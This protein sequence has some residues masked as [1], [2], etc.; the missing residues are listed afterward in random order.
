MGCWN[1][2]CGLSRLPIHASRA[3]YMVPIVQAPYQGRCYSTDMW[4]PTDIAVVGEYN[5]Y[6][7]GE[8]MEPV[9]M[10]YVVEAIRKNLVEREVGE[11]KYHDIAVNKSGFSE[12]MFFEAVH[13]SR[14]QVKIPHSASHFDVDMVMIRKD[15]VD[16]FK[17][18][19]VFKEYV[20]EGKG[21]GGY[22]NS[23]FQYK[24]SDLLLTVNTSL[25]FMQKHLKESAIVLKDSDFK[26]GATEEGKAKLRKAMVMMGVRS[27]PSRWDVRENKEI[28]AYSSLRYSI[29]RMGCA[30]DR[31]FPTAIGK[32]LCS[33]LLEDDMEKARSLAA[34]MLE[35]DFI[36]TCYNVTRN[37][38]T[39][40]LGE[41]SQFDDYQGYEILA[42][43]VHA[44]SEANKTSWEEEEE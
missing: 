11:N 18:N 25:E 37:L 40:M 35:M 20:G 17:E 38:W 43:A 6:G 26:E 29:D 41:G 3:V 15:V 24:W 2:T 33:A 23:Y 30:G 27:L 14:L 12:E 19:Y 21:N 5:D 28:L 9:A 42:N 13:E 10:G 44:A 8:N 34:H 1:K 7:G 32:D 22:G 4:T 16:H 31:L 39:P 36:M